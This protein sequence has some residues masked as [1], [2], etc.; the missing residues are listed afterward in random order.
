MYKKQHTRRSF[1]LSS[2]LTAMTQLPSSNSWTSAVLR[3][4]WHK[5]T[6][7]YDNHSATLFLLV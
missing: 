6:H 3:Q 7:S 2:Q 4:P 1:L 5:S